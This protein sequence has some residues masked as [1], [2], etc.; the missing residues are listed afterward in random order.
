MSWQKKLFNLVGVKNDLA[1]FF[2]LLTYSILGFK[3]FRFIWRF[4]ENILFWDQWDTFD[5]VLVNNNLTQVFLFQH[6]EHRMGVPLLIIKLM[7]HLTNWN[8]R[9]ETFLTGLVIF[10]SAILA[11]ILKN[12]LTKKL[13]IY[14]IIIPF[15]F[16]NLYQWENLIWGFQ[17][18]FVLP[19]FWLMLSVYVFTLKQSTT[20]DVVLLV[21][22]LL[23]AYSHFHGLFVSILIG[24][25]FALNFSVEK[26]R[27]RQYGFLFILT[28]FVMISYFLNYR[29]SRYLGP[30]NYDI[31]EIFRYFAYQINGFIG[32]FSKK[33]PVYLLS[34]FTL[35]TFVHLL[36]KTNIKKNLLR[37]Y[38]IFSLYLFTFMFSIAT[39]VGR[40]GVG[41]DSAYTS[42]YA[43]LIIPLFLGI[44]FYLQRFLRSERKT[45]VLT[46]ALAFYVFISAQN[47]HFNYI[48]A[49]N[50]KIS[51]ANWKQCYLEHESLDFCE[52][53][54]GYIIYHSPEKID[55]ESK[56]YY[57]KRNR[58]NFYNE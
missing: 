21:I 46:F 10:T 33:L 2:I 1:S 35:G 4:S 41:L 52:K 29:E 44:Y 5:A 47:N 56:L 18:G 26:T 8:V 42:R 13:E 45:L 58:L 16:L 31:I 28:T 9:F 6:N 54:K 7:A 17:I 15:L 24:I 27:R 49:E 32:L 55:L 50:R 43:T 19:L 34:F 3:F 20:R 25:F 30:G 57:L 11:L 40:L 12:K 39:A 23:S 38:S 53:T 14:D 36:I 48:Y 22:S 51:L 37:N